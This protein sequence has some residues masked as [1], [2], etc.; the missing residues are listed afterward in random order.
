MISSLIDTHFHLDFYKT[1]KK[2]YTEIN[3]M[4]QYTLCMTNSPGV[5]LSCKRLYSETK[6]LKF[7]LGFHPLDSSLTKYD[8]NDFIKFAKNSKYIGE[9]GLDFKS[10][11]ALKKEEQIYY[12]DRIVKL[13]AKDN[14]IFSVHI[15]GAES[16]L[17]EILKKYKPSKCIIHWYS[18]S[19]EHMNE[20][21][22]LGCYFSVNS[23]MLQAKQAIQRISLIPSHR[24]LIESDGPFTRVNG[25]KYLPNLLFDVYVMVATVR[26][27]KKL[28]EQVFNNFKRI[29]LD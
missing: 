12:F 15:K 1:H 24:L 10:A 13:C 23:N 14:K 22:L 27:E 18:G 2:I 11:N 26:K 4:K 21:I 16:K 7:A 3:E 6:Y 9:V 29:L 17:I 8:F 20:L 28:I 19:I 5:Y 25:V